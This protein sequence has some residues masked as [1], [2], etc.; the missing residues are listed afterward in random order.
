M[1]VR[2]TA[3]NAQG[4]AAEARQP[5]IHALNAGTI[6]IGTLTPALRERGW[7]LRE[8]GSVAAL[9]QALRQRAPAALLCDARMLPALTAWFDADPQAR[10]RRWPIIVIADKSHPR[11]AGADIWLVQ[12]GAAEVVR[13]IEKTVTRDEREPGR[14]LLVDDDLV[15]LMWCEGILRSN[16]LITATASS[17]GEAL[18]RLEEFRPDLVLVDLHMP[19]IDGM[20]LTQ[21]IRERSDAVLTPVVFLTGE[22]D[23]QRRFEA[24][25]NGGDDWLV[26]P[27]KPGDLITAVTSRIR[28]CREIVR[29]LS[30]PAGKA[31]DHGLLPRPEFLKLA[32]EHLESQETRRGAEALLILTIDQAGQLREQLGMVALTELEDAIA[33]QLIRF[34]DDGDEVGA[35]QEFGFAVLARRET[36]SDLRRLGERLVAFIRQKPYFVGGREQAL[37]ASVGFVNS[38]VA[39]RQLERWVNAAVAANQTVA[40]RGGNGVEGASSASSEGLSSEQASRLRDL[41]SQPLTRRNVLLEFQPLVP[42]RGVVL[43][44]YEVL[45]RLRDGD[46]AAFPSQRLRAVARELGVTD[47]LDQYLCLQA[48]QT[49]T[50]NAK[51]ERPLRLLLPWELNTGSLQALQELARFRNTWAAEGRSLGLI[52]D[53]DL[54]AAD[55]RRHMDAGQLMNQL[56]LRMVLRRVGGQPQLNQLF[57][58]L[59]FTLAILKPELLAQRTE[60]AALIRLAVD[61]GREV[62]VPDVSDPRQITGLW[63]LGAH[64]AMGDAIGPAGPRLDFAWSDAL[65]R[66]R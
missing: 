55:L 27:V 37:T 17:A 42:V 46:S 24:L 10:R 66:Q 18:E 52:L 19:G 50:E 60:A 43:G 11:A 8:F 47:R 54:V 49:L 28:R 5:L 57:D 21:R 26:K 14:V 22:T 62:V 41:L 40:R 30:A 38:S 45:L 44:Q 51:S 2:P 29:A 48:I 16:G 7:V 4:H 33:R 9:D 58:Q 31:R 59:P 3:V 20:E 65:L 32:R 12:P 13:E 15:Q 34:L 53:A 63:D 35:W 23:P 56:G 1:S 64:Y 61:F 25:G 6:L 39:R 36:D